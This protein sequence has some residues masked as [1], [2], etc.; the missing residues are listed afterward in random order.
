[1]AVYGY[2]KMR[3]RLIARGRDPAGIGRGRVTNVM[4]GL[5]VRGV[6]R[7][8]TPVTAKPVKCTG[9]TG[10]SGGKEVQGVGA[11]PAACRRHRLCAHGG[12]TLRLHGVRRRRVR[13]PRRR[14]GVRHRHGRR[15]AGVAI[16][17]ATGHRRRWKPSI[18]QTKRHEPP[19]YKGG[20][21]IRPLQSVFLQPNN[22]GTYHPIAGQVFTRNLLLEGFSFP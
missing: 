12:R 8:G 22:R 9:G 19:H 1:M 14:L 10:G 21:K 18:M 13:P 7:G 3:A 17:R 6:G 5:G 2:G 15:G 20:T 16:A 4:R 11:G